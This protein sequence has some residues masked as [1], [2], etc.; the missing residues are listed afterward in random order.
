MSLNKSKLEDAVLEYFGDL[1][2]AVGRGLHLPTGKQAVE[3][4]WFF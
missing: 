1:D 2:H 4:E 3:R